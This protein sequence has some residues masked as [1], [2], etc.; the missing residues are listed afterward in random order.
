MRRWAALAALL[1]AL[2][3]AADD[4]PASADASQA[5]ARGISVF[6]AQSLHDGTLAS[7]VCR[8]RSQAWYQHI[9]L[10]LITGRQAEIERLRGQ[11]PDPAGFDT[12][13]QRLFA[14]EQNR[15]RLTGDD[16]STGVCTALRDSAALQKLDDIE[17]QATGNYH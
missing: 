13:L 10:S 5:R 1:P 15:A 16:F 2:G 6:I 3:H 8:L 14:W 7:T 9:E 12:Y 4:A 11:A 17:R